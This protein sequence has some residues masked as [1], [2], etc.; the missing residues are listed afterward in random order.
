MQN[1]SYKST[2][3]LKNVFNFIYILWYRCVYW[4]PYYSFCNLYF[5]E[6]G[7]YN[8]NCKD[9]MR[10]IDWII[11]LN[12]LR[13]KKA[14]GIT[15]IIALANPLTVTKPHSSNQQAEQTLLYTYWGWN[16]IA[17][18]DEWMINGIPTAIPRAA[19]KTHSLCVTSSR[20]SLLMHTDE[21]C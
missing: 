17:I 19:N 3:K 13:V 15:N 5:S 21:A 9:N 10:V 1:L 14:N 20:S 2:K 7:Y 8:L 6:I 18:F 11:L 16:G 12:V 4:I